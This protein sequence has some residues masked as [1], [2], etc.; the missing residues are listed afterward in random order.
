MYKGKRARNL[1]LEFEEER[2]P[3][4]ESMPSSADW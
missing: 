1:E 2:G 3:L 4:R